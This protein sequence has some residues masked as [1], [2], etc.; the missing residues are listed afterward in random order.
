M[1]D[2][3]GREIFVGFDGI[4]RGK[5]GTSGREGTGKNVVDGGKRT[6]RDCKAG[7]PER[8]GHPGTIYKKKTQEFSSGLGSP[9]A[10]IRLACIC[11]YYYGGP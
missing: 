5:G 6:G 3:K 11:W 9:T 4:I 2:G 8:E 1:L 10:A 7:I